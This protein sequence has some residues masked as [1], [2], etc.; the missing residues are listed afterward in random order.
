MGMPCKY[1]FLPVSIYSGRISFM[2]NYF[3]KYSGENLRSYRITRMLVI[4]ICCH[5]PVHFIP[6]QEKEKEPIPCQ[7]YS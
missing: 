2:V 1:E 3:F 6:G 5:C 4:G 7:D